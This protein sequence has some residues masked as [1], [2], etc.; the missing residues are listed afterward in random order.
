MVRFVETVFPFEGSAGQLSFDVSAL[1]EVITEGEPNEWWEGR[2]G[3]EVGWFPSAYCSAPFDEGIDTPAGVAEDVG[4]AAP[5]GDAVQAVAL[6]NYEATSPDE[7][8]FA[9]GD[10]LEITSTD[11]AW[12]IG[13]KGEAVGC[14]PSNYVELVGTDDWDDDDG[15]VSKKAPADVGELGKALGAALNKARQGG[16]APQPRGA[17]D[18]WDDGDEG[19]AGATP[20]L[21]ETDINDVGC[22]RCRAWPLCRARQSALARAKGHRARR[23]RVRPHVRTPLIPIHGHARPREPTRSFAEM[24]MS[25]DGFAMGS[26][27]MW[28]HPAFGDMLVSAYAEASQKRPPVRGACRAALARC[29]YLDTHTHASCPAMHTP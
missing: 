26:R 18:E 3:A 15:D 4:A 6:Y 25:C 9:A 8:S 14:F 16:G 20:E 21:S 10:R 1:I 13:R 5:T 12:W 17:S 2:L 29:T 23:P 28:K 11:Q 24:P 19:D 27:P 7:L 22:A